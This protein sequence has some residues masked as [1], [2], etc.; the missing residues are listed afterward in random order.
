MSDKVEINQNS[1]DTYVIRKSDI[2]EILIKNAC[3]NKIM[4]EIPHDDIGNT[5]IKHL[6]Y[7]LQ[8]PKKMREKI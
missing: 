2:E 5:L 8:L 6:S 7:C 1:Y 4:M 3:I